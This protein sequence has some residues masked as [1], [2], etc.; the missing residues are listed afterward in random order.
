MDAE[1]KEVAEKYGLCEHVI[2]SVPLFI[3]SQNIFVAIDLCT[4]RKQTI[5]AYTHTRAS[6]RPIS[7]VYFRERLK[8][9]KQIVKKAHHFFFKNLKKKKM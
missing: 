2:R 8:Y 4:N 1:K 5:H 3:F 6:A 7:S 9:K